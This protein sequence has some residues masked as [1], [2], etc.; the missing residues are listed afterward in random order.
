MELNVN[1]QPSDN[2]TCKWWYKNM[3]CNCPPCQQ[4][5]YPPD[6][7]EAF[8]DNLLKVYGP[9]KVKRA[10]KITVDNPVPDHVSSYELTLTTTKD[11]PYELRT[12]LHKVVQSKM[13]GVTGFK[14][15][16]ELTQA[17][18]PHIHAILY[19]DK[20]Y[21]DATKI[22]TAI[23]YPYRYECVKVRD[24]VKYYNYL[25]KEK[26]NATVNIYCQ[27]KGIP[28]IWHTIDAKD[29]D[30]DDFVVERLAGDGWEQ[31]EQPLG[32]PAT[33]PQ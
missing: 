14:A 5:L 19:T 26:N 15:C 13:F 8:V 20:K 12:Y 4:L 1:G 7:F 22:R 2:C 21:V 3:G 24:P 27:Q 25:I 28:Q 33:L 29:T 31:L 30:N 23:K 9:K 6:D 18:L 10:P 11:D 16:I 32:L 17:G